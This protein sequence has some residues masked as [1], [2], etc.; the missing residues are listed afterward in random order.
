MIEDPDGKPHP[1]I[2]L[3]CEQFRFSIVNCMFEIVLA[4]SEEH[5][6]VYISIL[7]HFSPNFTPKIYSFFSKRLSISLSL[8]KT[9]IFLFV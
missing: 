3:S 6:L 9:S 5:L 7:I 1:Q 2:I 4:N 8:R